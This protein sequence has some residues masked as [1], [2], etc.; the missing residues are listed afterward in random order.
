MCIKANLL[1]FF[2]DDEL[3]RIRD[4]LGVFLDN[5]LDF[6]LFKVLQ[7]ILL[8]VEAQFGTTTKGLV[9]VVL[10]NGEGTPSSGFPNVLLVIVVFGDNL[11]SVGNKVCGVETWGKRL[12]RPKKNLLPTVVPTNTEL[13]NLHNQTRKYQ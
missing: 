1:N 8:Q 11:D 9:N 10:S 3:N 12:I 13:T 2:R 4:E 6:L 5:L 7:L